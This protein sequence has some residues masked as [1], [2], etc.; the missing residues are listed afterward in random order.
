M[1]A[2][3]YNWEM[4]LL[5]RLRDQFAS[6][7]DP[8]RF[9]AFV[10]LLFVLIL[11]LIWR[12]FLS[13]GHATP[14]PPVAP[15]KPTVPTTLRGE[16]TSL[17]PPS[18]F[19]VKVTNIAPTSE[20]SFDNKNETIQASTATFDVPALGHDKRRGVADLRVGDIVNITATAPVATAPGAPFV[21]TKISIVV[22]VKAKPHH[23]KVASIKHVAKKR[24]KRVAKTP[25]KLS[26]P[27]PAPKTTPTTAVSATGT[28]PPAAP[29]AGAV[30]PV[31]SAAPTNT[32][33]TATGT[34]VTTPPPTPTTT[35][36][37]TA[38][39]KKTVKELVIPSYT[40][41]IRADQPLAFYHLDQSS[42]SIATDSSGHHNNAYYDGGVQ[43]GRSGAISDDTND[44][45]VTLLGHPDSLISLPKNLLA[46]SQAFTFE[47]WVSWNGLS[48]VASTATS[49]AT[50]TYDQGLFTFASTQGYMSLSP[51]YQTANGKVQMQFEIAANSSTDE[52]V[53]NTHQLPSNSGWHQ[54]VLTYNGHQARIYLDGQEQAAGAFNIPL[55]TLGSATLTHALGEPVQAGQA[56]FSGGLDE[57]A[58]YPRVLSGPAIERHFSAGIGAATDSEAR[59]VYHQLHIT[60]KTQTVTVS[61][62]KTAPTTTPTKTT[63]ATT[64]GINKVTKT[65]SSTSPT[66][67]STSPTTSS[68][69]TSPTTTSPT[70]VPAPTSS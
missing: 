34:Q 16:I 54:L 36:K 7:P 9:F 61:S 53:L 62:K 23:V 46:H 66:T 44:T 58:F 30:A 38:A 27:K 45:A 65:T 2:G 60:P 8:R 67:S 29:N 52:E 5:D 12:L 39:N 33:V 4:G 68:A 43:L 3:C 6:I 11:L 32:A 15:A 31:T 13:G 35:P 50:K 10:G 57:V 69:S 41:F 22:T 40:D 24:H 64:T 55:S 19:A 70:S 18:T 21:A 59:E 56:T 20:Q 25:T 51:G 48:D 17:T 42:G 49:P 1:S 26:T 63:R 47:C 37:T 28:T 14:V